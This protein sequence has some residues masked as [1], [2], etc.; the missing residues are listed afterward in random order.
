M[1]SGYNRPEMR[2][3]VL[4]VGATLGVLIALVLLYLLLFL[5]SAPPAL[6]A[7]V[8]DGTARLTLQTVATYGHTPFPDWVSYLAEDPSGHWQHTTIYKVPAHTLVRVTL[9][10][11]DSATGLRNPFLGQ[12]RGTVGGIA[13]INGK[14]VSVLNPDDAAHTFTIPDIDVSVPLPGIS[15][16]AKNPCSVAPCSLA[17]SHNTIT[18]SFMSPGPG[19]YR[20]QCFV[21][22]GAGT[23]FGNGGPMQT[24]GY[25]NGLIEVT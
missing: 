21:P 13:R 11:Y 19:T 12:V 7:V 2:V 8:S 1:Q 25:M 16:K 22:C 15:A 17:Y 20:W 6:S 3:R 24:I 14:A 5:T 4:A 9:Y 23:L 18:F 10:Q